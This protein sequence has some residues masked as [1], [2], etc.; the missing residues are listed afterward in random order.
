MEIPVELSDLGLRLERWRS[1]QKGRKRLPEE[2]W[3]EAARLGERYGFD[4][5]ARVLRMNASVLR[6]KSGSRAPAPEFIELAR[7]RP[8]SGCALE[9]ETPH[10]KL[11]LEL[12]GMPVASIAELVRSIRA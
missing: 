7:P 12:G 1:S 3:R 5:V 9:L 11:R 2:Y 4:R 6:S 8:A 10:G